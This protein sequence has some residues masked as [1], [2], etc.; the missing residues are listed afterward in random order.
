MQLTARRSSIFKPV[1]MHDTS[2]PARVC[3]SFSEMTNFEFTPPYG[4]FDTVGFVC[5]VGPA[6]YVSITI[7][8]NFL[9]NLNVNIL[10]K[11]IVKNI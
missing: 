8:L 6:P 7:F 1:K 2:Y 3:T 4:E 10:F 11:K 9:A 5:F